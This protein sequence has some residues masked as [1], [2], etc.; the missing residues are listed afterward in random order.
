[1]YTIARL[2]GESGKTVGKGRLGA[3]DAL[4]KNPDATGAQVYALM[5]NTTFAKGVN[6]TE[7]KSTKRRMDN[8]AKRMGECYTGQGYVQNFKPGTT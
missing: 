3:L 1:M 7:Q 2:R 8:A 4:M 5:R 6:F